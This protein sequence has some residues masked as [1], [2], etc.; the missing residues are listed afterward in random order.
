MVDFLPTKL[1][2]ELYTCY[3]CERHLKFDLNLPTP[4]AQNEFLRSGRHLS[5]ANTELM[6]QEAAKTDALLNGIGREIGDMWEMLASLEN[7]ER[8]LQDL[9]TTQQ[10]YLAP[11]RRLPP[12]VLSEIFKLY[13]GDRCT[14]ITLKHCPPLVLGSVCKSWRVKRSDFTRGDMS[15]FNGVRTLRRLVIWEDSNVGAKDDGG[16]SMIP[17]HQLEEL[18][19]NASAAYALTLLRRCPQLRLWEHKGAV[20]STPLPAPTLPTPLSRLQKIGM[21]I[22]SLSDVKILKV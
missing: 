20:S 1:H 19:T 5:A 13:C 10:A 21:R 2:E 4:H 7:A 17:W 16:E 3:H 14:D 18:S 8:M 6:K 11:I 12:E 9:R 22:Y 15:F